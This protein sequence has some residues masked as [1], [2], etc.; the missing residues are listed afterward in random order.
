VVPVA[1]GALDGL[2]SIRIHLKKDL[3]SKE[4]RSMVR[5]SILEV[6]KRFPD[7]LPLLDPVEHMDIRDETFKKLI[8]ASYFEFGRGILTTC[9]YRKRKCWKL[10]CYPIHFTRRLFF[11]NSMMH[12]PRNKC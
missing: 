10:K 5:K 12:L 3:R 1:L 8:R 9:V 6:Q 11:P 4:D 2:G 7:G